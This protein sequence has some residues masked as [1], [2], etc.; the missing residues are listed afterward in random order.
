MTSTNSSTHPTSSVRNKP[1]SP[2][3]IDDMKKKGLC[4]WYGLKYTLRHNCVRSQ[5]YQMLLD[6][7]S[8]VEDEDNQDF[9]DQLEDNVQAGRG[10]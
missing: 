2:V 4:Y 6:F 1:L 10:D 8:D 5:L 9:L 3:E 7:T